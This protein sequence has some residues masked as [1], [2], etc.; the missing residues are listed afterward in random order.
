MYRLRPLALTRESSLGPGTQMRVQGR[1][2]VKVHIRAWPIMHYTTRLRIPLC[3]EPRPAALS[4]SRSSGW[5][6]AES[7]F[8]KKTEGV[9]GCR[10]LAAVH[11]ISVSTFL[12]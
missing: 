5:L 10:Q 11:G 1:G 4:A 9:T 2:A 8:A 3:F 12:I 7:V 6:V